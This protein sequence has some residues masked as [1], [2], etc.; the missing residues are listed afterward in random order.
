[1]RTLTS[2]LAAIA[3]A[4][5]CHSMKLDHTTGGTLGRV[6]VYRNGV[7]YYERTA[8][9]TDGTLAV[10][11][12]RERVDDFLK[13]LKVRDERTGKPIAVTI[14][15]KQEGSGGYL[16]MTLE[17]QRKAGNVV[18]TY[19]TEAPA[20]KPSY[21]IDV[22]A[23]HTVSL[24]GWAIV[25]NTTSEDWKGVLVGVGASSALA[26][27]Y[28]LWSVRTVDRDLLGGD[29]KFAVAPPAGVSPYAGGSNEVLATYGNPD[30]TGVSFSGSS[31]LENQYVVDGV[32][33]TSTAAGGETI[34]IRG[35]APVIDQ[36]S[37]K[38]G[39]TFSADYTRNI[40]VGRT[41]GAVLGSSS[42]AQSPPPPPTV[43]TDAQLKAWATRLRESHKQLVIRVVGNAADQQRAETVRTRAI[44]AGI[45]SSRVKVDA[46]PATDST[47]QLELL[48]VAAAAP[49]APTAPPGAISH[50]N[51][52]DAP[53]GESNFT[54][55]HPITVKAGSS[56]M[57][58]MITGKTNG[59]IV[60]L[61]DPIS[62][63]GDERFAFKAV[64]A[65]NPTDGTL[66][67]GPVT[68]YGDDEKVGRFIGEGITE[69]VPPHAAVIVPFAL[70]K[71]VVVTRE[72]SNDDVLDKLITVER[73]KL[74][75]QLQ[76]QRT[77]AFTVTNRGAVAATVYLRHKL[78][79]N[80][81]LVKAPHDQMSI[82]DSKL[83]AVHLDAG[84]TQIVKVVEATPV[85][86][87]LDLS[88]FQALGY[89]KLYVEG[90][91]V[92]AALKPKL[93][94]VLFAHRTVADLMAQ[95]DTN[96][97]QLRELDA[98]A[99]ELRDQ[100]VA[101]QK[102]KAGGTLADALRARLGELADRQQ[103]ATLAVVDAQQ[104]LMLARIKFQNLLADLSLPDVRVSQK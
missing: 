43:P 12:P 50:G 55:D 92:N 53:V 84:E 82:G 103:K 74:T 31:S 88:T 32:N 28:D 98:R 54:T 36:G 29:E 37:T 76:N 34:M 73:G 26:F 33:T 52:S 72:G 71:E 63:R 22:H 11:V 80:W 44:D 17:T 49:T 90:P 24:E 19:V 46:T 21:R 91:D 51:A 7:A 60:Y 66:E 4:A 15:R 1:M 65:D 99:T 42:A 102:V 9:V 89:V 96:R 16:T 48:A 10:H 70:D 35:S 77:T 85:Q 87:T 45:P 58:E 104:A 69:A 2:A 93:E 94:E 59:G 75:V 81:T 95:I 14:P 100:V 5:G 83:F 64:R 20:W 25:D 57:V 97:D 27:R 62:D 13:S 23:D 41:F 18:I 79:P 38:S 8:Q 3:F 68:V 78:E 56:A 101:L 61:Y 47:S 67:A 30:A 39:T 40:P 86:R 6:V